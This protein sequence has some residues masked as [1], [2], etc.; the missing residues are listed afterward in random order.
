MRNRRTGTSSWPYFNF[1]PFPHLETGGIVSDVYKQRPANF[2]EIDGERVLST[3]RNRRFISKY[4]K[5]ISHDKKVIT[6]K[7]ILP[8]K[9]R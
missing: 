8:L 3:Y 2:S 6:W 7:L 5:H 9:K 1:L 4:R